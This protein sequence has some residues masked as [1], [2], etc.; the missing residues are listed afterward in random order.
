MG[1]TKGVE[2]ENKMSGGSIVFKLGRINDDELRWR[3]D[4][5]DHFGWNIHKWNGDDSEPIKPGEAIYIA[6]STSTGRRI[7]LYDGKAE[8]HKNYSDDTKLTFLQPN[9]TYVQPGEFLYIVKH[10]D[11]NQYLSSTTPG[12]GSGGYGKA[13]ERVGGFHSQIKIKI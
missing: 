4:D 1:G 6:S 8:A 13:E 11:K 12:N 5:S 2:F 3:K 9:R 10:I 7:Y